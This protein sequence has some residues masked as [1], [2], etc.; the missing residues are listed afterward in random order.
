MSTFSVVSVVIVLKA[1]FESGAFRTRSARIL[2]SAG[3][4]PIT[5]PRASEALALFRFHE[6]VAN[7]Y[8]DS[9][10]TR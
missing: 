7:S 10:L 4:C 2:N 1:R 3:V 6:I 9:M 5:H 8:S